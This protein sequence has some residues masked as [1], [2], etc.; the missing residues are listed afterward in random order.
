MASEKQLR[1]NRENAKRSS[2][3]KTALGRL[4]SSRNALRHG[5]SLPLTAGPATSMKVR[6]MAQMLVPEG[7]DDMQVMAAVEMAQ[8]QSQLL[9]VSSVRSKLLANLDLA[10]ANL[11]QLRQLAALDRYD[12]QALTRRSR[13]PG[14]LSAACDGSTG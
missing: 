3:P 14:R 12:R 8:A 6:Q 4:K 5:L 13:A 10:L 9:R 1:A 11:K 7:A 2:G